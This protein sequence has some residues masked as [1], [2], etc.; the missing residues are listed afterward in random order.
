MNVSSVVHATAVSACPLARDGAVY[1]G[2]GAA[3]D[4]HATPDVQTLAVGLAAPLLTVVCCSLRLPV[5][6]TA[7]MRKLGAV[8][9]A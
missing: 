4:E 6:A 3:F 2:D 8:S 9:A 5:R 1:E 7:K